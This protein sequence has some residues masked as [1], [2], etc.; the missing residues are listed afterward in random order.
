MPKNRGFIMKKA[1]NITGKLLLGLLLTV[2]VLLLCTF[3]FNKVS[4][5]GDKKL[6]NNHV[7][8]FSCKIIKKQQIIV[9]LSQYYLLFNTSLEGGNEFHISCRNTDPNSTVPPLS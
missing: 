4:L 9:F 2:L 6:I 8:I 7:D 5:A 3:I 1:L